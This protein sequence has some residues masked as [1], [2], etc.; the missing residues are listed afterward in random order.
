MWW[1]KQCAYNATIGWGP[2]KCYVSK[3]RTQEKGKKNKG[4]K[5]K[6]GGSK[7]K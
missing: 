7:G 3:K 2:S 5:G 1:W 6:K 4:K